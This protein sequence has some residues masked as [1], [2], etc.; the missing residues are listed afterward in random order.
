LELT[1]KL[2]T[3]SVKCVLLLMLL[4]FFPTSKVTKEAEILQEGFSLIYRRVKLLPDGNN[5]NK[6]MYPET[7]KPPRGKH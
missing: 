5:L 3:L 6:S 1:H 7:N 2:W 4:V